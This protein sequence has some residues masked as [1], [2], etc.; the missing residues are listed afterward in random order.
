MFLIVIR[1]ERECASTM[2]TLIFA[3]IVFGMVALH[4]QESVTRDEWK[5][6]NDESWRLSFLL[7]PEFTKSDSPLS[8]V[9][10]LSLPSPSLYPR[11]CSDSFLPLFTVSQAAQYLGIQPQ[12]NASKDSEK[13]EVMH[14]TIYYSALLIRVIRQQNQLIASYQSV[15]QKGFD[16]D[17]LTTIGAWEAFHPSHEPSADSQPT[18]GNGAPPAPVPLPPLTSTVIDPQTGDVQVIV[19]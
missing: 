15:P 13:L 2:K 19:H 11:L 8:H 12:W 17:D 3:L 9:Y 1:A 18:Q 6:E 10:K 14:Q 4:A 7:F 5:Y 16:P